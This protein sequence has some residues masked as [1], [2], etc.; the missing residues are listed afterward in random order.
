MICLC[1]RVWGSASSTPSKGTPTLILKSSDQPL[2][3]RSL[4]SSGN[5]SHEP[6]ERWP[7]KTV[8]A[9]TA[10]EICGV[11][12]T[13]CRS[14]WPQNLL[15]GDSCT[16]QSPGPPEN[17][18]AGGVN[19]PGSSLG[20]LGLQ[21]LRSQEEAASHSQAGVNSPCISP[22][23]DGEGG[24]HRASCDQLRG[25]S[26]QALG[27]VC[28]ITPA[29][30]RCLTTCPSAQGNDRGPLGSIVKMKWVGKWGALGKCQFCWGCLGASAQHRGAG[31][32][33]ASC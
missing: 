14:L 7:Q 25:W 12:F 17:R 16:T 27:L 33:L 13:L 11:S 6:L 24:L 8:W 19:A 2:Q 3:D 30:D 1:L 26:A 29:W 18:E 9:E 15:Q 20:Y 4:P 5:A 21:E 23:Q 22:R 31:Q 10:G 28:P 32:P